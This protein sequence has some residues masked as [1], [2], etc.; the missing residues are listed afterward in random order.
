[1]ISKGRKGGYNIIG[2]KERG[3]EGG[4]K[5][6]SWGWDFAGSRNEKASRAL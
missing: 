4:G 5:R 1:M 3:R 2:M 6:A